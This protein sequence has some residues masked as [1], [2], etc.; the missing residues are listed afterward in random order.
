MAKENKIKTSNTTIELSIN[1]AEY[2]GECS[3]VYIAILD[4]AEWVNI[5]VDMPIGHDIDDDMVSI[6]TGGNEV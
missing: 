2:P 3:Y 5:R 4:G 1:G 6:R